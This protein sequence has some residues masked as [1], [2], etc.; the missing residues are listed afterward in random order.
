MV[1]C[2]ALVSANVKYPP[3]AA[4]PCNHEWTHKYADVCKHCGEVF[5]G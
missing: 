5:I 2:F 3:S 1:R 4:V